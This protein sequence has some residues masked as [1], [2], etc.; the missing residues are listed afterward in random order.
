MISATGG[1]GGA[2]GAGGSS[3]SNSTAAGGANSLGAV[4]S[5]NSSKYSAFAIALPSPVYTPPA[6]MSTCPQA[7]V[8]SHS[9]SV[10]WNFVSKSDTVQDA[11][12]CTLFPIYQDLYARCKWASA[13]KL[14]NKMIENALPGYTPETV[15]AL[16][17]TEAECAAYH[18]PPPAPAPL[19]LFAAP[20]APIVALPPTVIRKRA[21]RKLAPKVSPCV[22]AQ[23]VCKSKT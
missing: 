6:P 19:S 12:A 13:Q 7:S 3:S 20:T 10:G 18:A 21:P 17:L 22:P 9:W 16:D 11:S 5:G 1:A 15:A 8:Q 2:G 23:N 14:Q 4:D